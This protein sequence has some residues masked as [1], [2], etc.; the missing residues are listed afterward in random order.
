MGLLQIASF[1]FRHLLR[2]R[3]R[4]HEIKWLLNVVVDVVVQFDRDERGRFI[5]EIQYE[6]RRLRFA[7]REATA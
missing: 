2:Q 5:S 1:H 7:H 6:P 4:L 3:L